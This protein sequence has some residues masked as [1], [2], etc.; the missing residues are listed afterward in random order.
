MFEPLKINPKG[1]VELGD[2]PSENYGPRCGAFLYDR[3]AVR[4]GEF[5]YRPDIAGS[6]AIVAQIPALD[7]LRRAAGA[8]KFL[9]SIT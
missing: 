6:A 4:T 9:D 3:E 8:V 1:A 2:G 5:L 7:V